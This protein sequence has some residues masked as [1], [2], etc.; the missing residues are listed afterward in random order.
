MQRQQLTVP[1]PLLTLMLYFLSLT[2]LQSAHLFVYYCY[3]NYHNYNY[4]LYDYFRKL[5]KKKKSV[6][7]QKAVPVKNFK[8]LSL[9]KK[10]II[11][12]PIE[13]FIPKIYYSCLICNS[14]TVW[15]R[16][17]RIWCTAVEFYER[18]IFG[19]NFFQHK[20]GVGMNL[21]HTVLTL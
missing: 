10:Q 5:Y 12:V 11:F 14:N 1:L 16:S 3:Y 21:S 19:T 15:L 4:H 18:F 7:F 20:W 8:A 2:Y 9:S 6:L 13:N 17:I